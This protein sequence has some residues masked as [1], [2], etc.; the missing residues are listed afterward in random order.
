MDVRDVHDEQI[1]GCV[2]S[3]SEDTD[4]REGED[5]GVPVALDG[6]DSTSEKEEQVKEASGE[7]NSGISITVETSFL[8]V[9]IFAE[10]VNGGKGDGRSVT[11]HVSLPFESRESFDRCF[12]CS[13]AVF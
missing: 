12:S 11:I 13:M 8:G 5:F 1:S 3:E 4:V 10:V 9:S 2:D 7:L 6:R